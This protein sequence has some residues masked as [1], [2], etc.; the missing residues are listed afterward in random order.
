MRISIKL[1]F[2]HACRDKDRKS[3][4]K[5]RSKERHSSRRR[6]HKSEVTDSSED[7]FGGYVPRKRQEAP[8]ASKIRAPPATREPF[9]NGGCAAQAYRSSNWALPSLHAAWNLHLW[10]KTQGHTCTI[11]GPQYWQNIHTAT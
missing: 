3:R 2:L 4:H 8:R 1:H 9:R 10:R 11:P 7:E 6:R 5:S